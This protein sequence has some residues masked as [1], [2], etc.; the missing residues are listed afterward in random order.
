MTFPTK[1]RECHHTRFVFNT[2]CLP[3][4]IVVSTV[5]TT[6][7][8][9]EGAGV[10][11][12]SAQTIIVQSP[13][14]VS[15]TVHDV[16]LHRCTITT[17]IDAGV[18]RGKG[19][20][21][22]YQSCLTSNRRSRSGHTGRSHHRIHHIHR[23]SHHSR[24]SILRNVL[25]RNHHGSSHHHHSSRHHSNHVRNHVR[26]LRIRLL[27]SSSIHRRRR[28]RSNRGHSR[29]RIVLPSSHH[30]FSHDHVPRWSV[31][32]TRCNFD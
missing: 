17:Q 4:I 18:V 3:I 16:I 7:S 14:A 9:V 8:V 31:G 27:P 2:F 12:S 30:R 19:A 28:R 21:P 22:K 32:N 13:T 11:S 26:I 20:V 23:S 24:R 15:T 29:I 5:T 1:N 10:I 6:I 25:D